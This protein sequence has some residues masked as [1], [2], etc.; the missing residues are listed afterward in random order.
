MPATFAH[1]FLLRL[2]PFKES[3]A[4][5]ELL[6]RQLGKISLMARG[7]RRSRKRFGGALDY[8]CLFDAEVVPPRSGMG[9]LNSVELRHC[10][11][12]IRNDV[13][14]FTAAGHMLDVMRMGT[15]EGDPSQDPFDLLHGALDALDADTLSDAGVTALVL[16]FQIK[17]IAQL[18][19][20]LEG[21]YCSRCSEPVGEGALSFA[22]LAPVCASCADARS[23]A[24]SAGA[25]KTLAAAQRAHNAKLAGLRITDAIAGELIPLVESALTRALGAEPK[26][27]GNLRR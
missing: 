15:R 18:G 6:T 27:L 3:D 24:I 20:G 25:R 13:D 10:F 21:D 12:N 22:D 7:A 8:L 2:T 14:R 1:A 11:D 17:M 23:V 4:V 19:Y 26:T 9:R 16:I 5:V